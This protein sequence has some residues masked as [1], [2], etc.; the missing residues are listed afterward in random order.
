MRT[1]QRVFVVRPRGASDSIKSAPVQVTVDRRKSTGPSLPGRTSRTSGSDVETGIS[2]HPSTHRKSVVNVV[3][4]EDGDVEI[5]ME[6][7]EPMVLTVLEE[8]NMDGVRHLSDKNRST[9]CTWLTLIAIFTF[10]ALYQIFTQLSMYITTPVATNIEAD[11]PTKI[12]FPTI[13]ICN[14]NQFRLTYLTGARIQNR[15]TKNRTHS[16]KDIDENSTNVFDKALLNSGDMDALKFLRNAAHWKSRMIL[17]CTWPN[18]T[19]CRMTD[20]K[21]VWTLTGL[22]WAINTDPLNPIFVTGAGSAHAL[23]LLLNIERY[24]RVESCTPKFR[25]TSLPGIKIL[26]YNQTDIPITSLNGVNV[27]PGF[28][29]D[30][31]F[32]MKQRHKF[33]GFNCIQESKEHMNEFPL[34]FDNPYNTQTCLIRNY[35]AEIER[36]C[37]CSMRRAYNPNPRGG[38]PFCNVDDYFSCVMP[39]LKWGYDGGFSTYNC[40]SSCEEIDYVAWQDMNELPNNIFPKLIDSMDDEDEMDVEASDSDLDM[41]EEVYEDLTKDEHY[42][43]EHNQILED[44]QVN[45]IKREAHRAYEK[46]ARY[47]EDMLLRTKKLIMKMKQSA[48]KLNDL[49]WGWHHT[50]FKGVYLRLKENIDCYGN[51]SLAHQDVFNAITNPAAHG[52]ER[53]ANQLVH[54]L[55]K[56]GRYGKIEELRTISDVKHAYGADRVEKLATQLQDIDEILDKLHSIYNEDTYRTKLSKDLEKVDRIIQLIDQFDTGKLQKRAWAEKMQSRNMR[57]FFDEDFYEDWYNVVTKDLDQNLV[58]TINDLEDQIEYLSNLTVNGTGLE[59]GSVLLFGDSEV[60]H[61]Q[62]FAS[63]LDDILNCTLG[64]VRNHSANMLKEFKKAMHDFQAAYTNLFKK[65]LV[66]YLDN[67]EFGNKFV[68]ENFGIVN[69]FLHKMNIEHWRQ[70]ATYSFWSMLCDVGGALGLFLGAS[71]LTIIELIYLCFQY[72]F[73]RKSWDKVKGHPCTNEN[74]NGKN[75]KDGKKNGI[76][77]EIEEPPYYSEFSLEPAKELSDILTNV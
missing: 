17:K 63:F 65:E 37:A 43:C 69:V 7:N 55:D 60:K 46:Q 27:P 75:Q 14:N 41:D 76:T 51:I 16:F 62:N 23:R 26:I 30:I 61:V 28:T 5:I 38:I 31:P 49:K 53:R 20:F 19:S 13:A 4:G 6:E 64:P 22:C 58:R 1:E 68:R 67:F 8:T 45:R 52:E 34:D 25:T 47:Q 66:E 59:M 48:Q 72:G 44:G 42:K 36:Q 29:M 40:M 10:L 74:P 18:G 3:E 12:A 15:R 21:A 33:P 39:V 32:Y 35:L 2:S 56:N 77:V 24:E 57:H 71:L 70:D 9:R 54:L 73:C 50:N 11:Y